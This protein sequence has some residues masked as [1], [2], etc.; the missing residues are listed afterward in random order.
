MRKPCTR[1]HEAAINGIKS[2]MGYEDGTRCCKVCDFF[3]ESQLMSG[4]HNANPARCE[5]NAMWFPVS[6]SGHCDEFAPRRSVSDPAQEVR[7]ALDR[8]PVYQ[9]VPR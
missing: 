7:E 6:E 5:R 3:G 8:I 9:T 4:A 2:A 1:L